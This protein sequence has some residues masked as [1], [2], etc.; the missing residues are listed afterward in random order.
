M[1]PVGS[2][3]QARLDEITAPAVVACGELDMPMKIRRSVE[4]AEQLPNGSYRALPGR[5]HLPY[6]EAADEVAALIIP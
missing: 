4:L 2:T 5:A 6:L 3:R 1:V